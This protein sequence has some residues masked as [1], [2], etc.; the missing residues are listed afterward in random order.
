MTTFKKSKPPTEISLQ[1]LITYQNRA[2]VTFSLCS[3]NYAARHED[4]WGCGGTAP[5]F[6][7]LAL[8]GGEWSASH[9]GRFTAGK[10]APLSIG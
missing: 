2:K 4:I 6:S 10:K 8:D 5:P 1:K 7:A 9:P 3:I